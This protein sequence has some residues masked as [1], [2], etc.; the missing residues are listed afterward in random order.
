MRLKGIFIFGLGAA[1]GSVIT[2]KIIRDKYEALIDDEI[3]SVKESL[4]YYNNKTEDEQSTTSEIDKKEKTDPLKMDKKDYENMIA[5]HKYHQGCEDLAECEHPEDDSE[6]LD[7]DVVDVEDSLEMHVERLTRDTLPSG[8]FKDNIYYISP[9]EYGVLNTY[10][11][12]D[13]TLYADGVLCD[14]MDELVED[15]DQK[16]GIEY[17]KYFGINEDEPDVIHIRNDIYKCDYEI[18]RDLREYASVVWG[19]PPHFIE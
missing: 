15:W 1:I 18:T 19:R 14:D 9:E 16:V 8:S 4:G 12:I 11:L 3:E 17:Q 7:D 10:E 5:Y 2:Y 6:E 13:L